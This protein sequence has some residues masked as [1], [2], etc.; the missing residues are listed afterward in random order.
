MPALSSTREGY[1]PSPIRQ[2]DSLLDLASRTG[3]EC[4]HS[5]V[6]LLTSA[7]VTTVTTLWEGVVDL[8]SGQRASSPE[9]MV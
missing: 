4:G 8:W 9:S 7:M 2:T 6:V 1:L 5:G 3:F